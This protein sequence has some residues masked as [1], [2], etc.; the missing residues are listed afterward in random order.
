MSVPED[1]K[2]RPEIR[3]GRRIKVKRRTEQAFD[4]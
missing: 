1:K 4:L 2:M 3:R